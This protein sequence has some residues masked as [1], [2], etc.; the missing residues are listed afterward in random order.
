MMKWVKGNP[1]RALSVGA[2]IMGG[3][4][5]AA[6]SG[7]LQALADTLAALAPLFGG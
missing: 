6:G 7:K 4:A 3:A 2:V 5:A 1:R